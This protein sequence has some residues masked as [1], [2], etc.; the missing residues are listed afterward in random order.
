MRLRRRLQRPSGG[1]RAVKASIQ[2]KDLAWQRI[3]PLA[4]FCLGLAYIVASPHFEASDSDEHAGMIQ[5]LAETGRLPIQTAEHDALYGQEASQ[6]PLYYAVMALIW[7]ML[8]T[9]DFDAVYQENPLAINGDPHRLGSRNLVFY[10]QP[11]PPVLHGTSLALYV[12]RLATLAMGAVTVYAVYQSARI[13]VPSSRD[14][15]ILAA[16]LVAFNPMFVFISASI[17]NDPPVSMLTALICWRTLM[18]LRDGFAARRSV[19]LAVLIALATLTKL[20]GIAPGFAAGLAALWLAYRTQD[21]RG[22][23]ALSL[24]V[25]LVWLL[26]AGWWYARNL[27]LYGELF[28]TGSMLDFYGRRTITLGGLVLEEFEGLRISYWGLFGAFSILTHKAFYLAMDLLSLLGALGLPLALKSK[29]RPANLRVNAAFLGLTLALGGA[30]LIWWSLQ[31][32]A[33]TGRL[34]FPYIT[35]ISIL[36]AL[37]IN[38]LRIPSLLICLPLFLFTLACPFLYIKPQYEHPPAVAKLPESA[39]PSF[40]R[41]DDITLV[42]YEIPEPRRWAAGDEIPLTVYWQPL[43]Q[44]RELQALFITLID[45][46]GMALATIDSFPG[47]GTLPTTWWRPGVIYRDDY[48]LQI[49]SDTQAVSPIQLHIG[50]YNWSDRLDIM[51]RSEAD[52]EYAAYTLPLGA[53]VAADKLQQTLGGDASPQGKV[54]GDAL[55]LNAYDFSAG[56][57]L[58]MEWQVLAAISGDWRAFAIVLDKPYQEGTD[59]AVI[60]QKDSA[61]PVPLDFLKTGETFITR[62]EF[63]LPAGYIGEH[64]IYVGWYNEA[65]GMRLAAPFPQNM[66]ELPALLFEANGA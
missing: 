45:A 40:A 3:L 9:T 57:A 38:A 6:P 7:R 48:I 4:F 63:Q 10:R 2:W 61:P 43:A 5:W 37:G 26:T 66:L 8:D 12:I 42:G 31:T 50:W 62:H 17:S 51:P 41:W 25:L 21:W 1:S 23:M 11:Y 29:R 22:F 16:S 44:S 30:M 39:S 28:G 46:E 32:T 24:A 19:I 60:L 14:F 58:E 53:I 59:F 13:V 56:H 33:S 36:L 65:L 49:P 52:Q 35:S 27:Q 47:W 18:M 54:F 15:A 55:K 34:L 64:G 20:S